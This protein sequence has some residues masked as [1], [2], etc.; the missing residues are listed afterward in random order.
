M[1][2][3]FDE[4]NL[5]IIIGSAIYVRKSKYISELVELKYA[6]KSEAE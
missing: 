4:A 1:I 5:S 2:N 3:I 6:F